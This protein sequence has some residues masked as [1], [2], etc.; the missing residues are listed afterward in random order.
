M[1]TPNRSFRCSFRCRRSRVGL[2][3]QEGAKYL[4]KLYG[5]RGV[6]LGGVPGVAPGKVV[7][8]G[9]GIVGNQ[10]GEDGGRLGA[11]V[12]ILDISLDRLRYLSDVM[13]ANCVLIHSNRYNI[14]EAISTADLA[15][16]Q[17]S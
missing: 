11:Q 8:L 9:V 7:I 3:V 14:L 4:E 6:L 17:C 16:A 10:R 12:T 2:A 5:G 1:E 15:L 13:P